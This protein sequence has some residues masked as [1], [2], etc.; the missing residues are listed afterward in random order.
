MYGHRRVS[1]R[2]RPD[3]DASSDAERMGRAV[4]PATAAEVALI[5]DATAP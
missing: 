5:L 1:R 3:W 4:P 2:L